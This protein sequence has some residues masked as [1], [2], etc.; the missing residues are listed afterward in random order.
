MHSNHVGNRANVTQQASTARPASPHQGASAFS[1]AM[2]RRSFHPKASSHGGWEGGGQKP[3]LSAVK[4]SSIEA[5]R[6]RLS[7]GSRHAVDFHRGA[8]AQDVCARGR[9]VVTHDHRAHRQFGPPKVARSP[10]S[11]ILQHCWTSLTVLALAGGQRGIMGSTMGTGTC[12]AKHKT[13]RHTCSVL[14]FWCH[15]RR[16][17]GSSILPRRPC[18]RR[19]RCCTW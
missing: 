14:V 19:S 16:C 10:R 13:G 1:T 18:M 2:T 7:D 3:W 5:W 15:A 6:V 17:L 12:A 9:T 11:Q 4:G 8:R